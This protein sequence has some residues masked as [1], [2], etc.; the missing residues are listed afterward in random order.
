M[1]ETSLT[2]SPSINR[3]FPW[4]TLVLWWIVWGGLIVLGI[5]L[6]HWQLNRAEYKEEL[7][8]TWQSS[9]Y[10]APQTIPPLNYSRIK[11]TGHWLSHESL[12]WDNRI[13]NSQVGISLLTPFL[14]TQRQLWLINRG[15]LATQGSR[16]QVPIPASTNKLITIDGIWQGLG[17]KN[18]MV[19]I[20]REGNRIQQIDTD[21][22]ITLGDMAEGV[23]HQV[24]GPDMLIAH[25]Q[26]NQS[27]AQR[28]YGY[29]IQ[30]ILLSL[31]ATFFAFK[32]RPKIINKDP[33]HLYRPEKHEQPMIRKPS[34]NV[35]Q[36]K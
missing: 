36:R 3:K 28:H 8:Q 15:F 7:I 10:Q 29:F 17:D 5:H 13:F 21:Q 30:W 6:A 20:N 14:D 16:L 33:N 26:P 25:W 32:Y 27:A 9:R 22:W 2:R 23:V 31:V 24:A 12:W 1:I 11:L 4:L 18:P 35:S 19:G 34:I